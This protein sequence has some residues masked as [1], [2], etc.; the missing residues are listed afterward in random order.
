M[1][2]AVLIFGELTYIGR[3][4]AQKA[5]IPRISVALVFKS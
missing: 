4:H 1:C 3:S 2:L 5:R